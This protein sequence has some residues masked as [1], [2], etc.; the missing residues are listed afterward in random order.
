MKTIDREEVRKKQSAGAAIVDVLTAEKFREYHI[1]GA[2]NVPIGHG[3]NDRIQAALPD[4]EQDVVVYCYDEDCEA[5]SKAGE[6]MEELG[7][8]NTYDYAAGKADWKEAGLTV[9]S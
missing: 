4:K 6:R 2:I 9:E 5:S 1:P 7:Y 3:F 8:S